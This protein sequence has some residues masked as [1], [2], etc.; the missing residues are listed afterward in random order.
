MAEEIAALG[1]DW[2]V[3]RDGPLSGARNMALDHALAISPRPGEGIVRLYSWSPTTVSFGR[4]EPTKAR[5]DQAAAAERGIEFVRR[6]TGGRAVLHDA[7]LTY[8]VITPARAFGG[9]KAAYLK[10]NQG[11][12][13]GLSRL[14]ADAVVTEGGAVLTPE[15]GACF[16]V[17]APG[18]VVAGGRKLVGSAQVRVGGV[19]LQ[20]GSIILDG[21]QSLLSELTSGAEDLAQP[22]TLRSLIGEVDPEELAKA[23]TEGLQLALGGSW[24]E[25]EY[26]SGELAEARWLERERYGAQ[27]WTWRQ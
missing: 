26:R 8:A 20:H 19:L 13:R 22:A 21:D 3:I 24:D 15:A 16:Q 6:P 23:V 7:E 11:L 10:I 5:Y 17:P 2:R 27:E 25:G 12:A 9:P 18:E 1:L 4:N 14:G